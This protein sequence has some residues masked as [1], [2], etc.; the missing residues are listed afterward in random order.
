MGSVEDQKQ[1]SKIHV[2]TDE[3]INKHGKSKPFTESWT[4]KVIF[5]VGTSV[6][7]ALLLLV[8]TIYVNFD[9][10]QKIPSNIE[11][12][13]TSL[14]GIGKS[15]A[16]I[17]ERMNKVEETHR[18]VYY[19]VDGD[20]AA[21]ILFKK[22]IGYSLAMD[23]ALLVVRSNSQLL[24]SEAISSIDDLKNMR[25]KFILLQGE[26]KGVQTMLR[27]FIAKTT[28]NKKDVRQGVDLFIGEETAKLLVNNPSV[29]KVRLKFKIMQDG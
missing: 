10:F 27:V 6:V 22:D 25:G 28:T 14:D 4:F 3:D 1:D 21:G 26:E 29:G 12:I 19:G 5:S 11:N 9:S 24:N 15:Y 20:L 18:N 23:E 2:I 17:N 8:P 16:A 13:A 7:A